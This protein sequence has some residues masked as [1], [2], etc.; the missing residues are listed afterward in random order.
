MGRV[1]VGGGVWVGFWGG[2]CCGGVG[3]GV[4]VRV[5]SSRV[6]IVCSCGGGRGCGGLLL[7][8]FGGVVRRLFMAVLMGCRVSCRVFIFPVFCDIFGS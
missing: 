5:V 8:V 4:W 1:V 6:A 2:V 3:G 7:S